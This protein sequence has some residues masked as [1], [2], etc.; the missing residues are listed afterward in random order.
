ME[1]VE[2]LKQENNLKDKETPLFTNNSILNTKSYEKNV[3]HNSEEVKVPKSH[4]LV[5]DA[6]MSKLEALNF[7]R[8]IMDECTH[9]GNFTPPVDPSLS[10][11]V[12]AKHDAYVPREGIKSIGELWQGCEIRYIDAGHITAFLFNQYMFRYVYGF[13]VL[14]CCS[15]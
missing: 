12:S 3:T 4:Q 9:L 8:G 13:F 15:C 2:Q 6:E 5:N 10:I 11:V 1:H 7:M 14:L